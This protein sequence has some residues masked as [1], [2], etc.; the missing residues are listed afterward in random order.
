[1]AAAFRSPSSAE[2]KSVGRP[3]SPLPHRGV[4]H[5]WSP[6]NRTTLGIAP[7]PPPCGQLQF[8]SRASSPAQII[9][10]DV[11]K[12]G[13]FLPRNAFNSD[14]LLA[15][16]VVGRTDDQNFLRVGTHICRVSEYENW[17]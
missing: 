14:S 11:L 2:S 4:G 1:M 15:S 16:V 6:R 17:I 7:S 12:A 5:R 3:K 10:A 8:L 9:I 13:K